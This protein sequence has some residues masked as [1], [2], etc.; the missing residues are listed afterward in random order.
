MWKIQK[1]E[2]ATRDSS[3]PVNGDDDAYTTAES[4]PKD[5]VVPQ[6]NYFFFYIFLLGHSPIPNSKPL[7]RKA[8]AAEPA[9]TPDM[10]TAEKMALEL[11]QE[12][13]PE[14]AQELQKLI[15]Q[16]QQ[17]DIKCLSYMHVKNF[18][19]HIHA[20]Y[21]QSFYASCAWGLLQIRV[22]Q[23]ASWHDWF[24][25]SLVFWLHKL[26]YWLLIRQ[27]DANQIHFGKGL[28]TVCLS[29]GHGMSWSSSPILGRRALFQQP[30][31][32]TADPTQA[33]AICGL[34]TYI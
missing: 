26:G 12:M 28:C 1:A 31:P 22:C 19:C 5:S 9:V 23:P 2:W 20:M 8:S 17:L 6:F 34:E 4:S 3:E 11:D 13:T 10:A 21:L 18:T 32:P 7:H 33:T 15:A 25:K 30:S 29:H 27:K 24:Y 14:Q 16:L